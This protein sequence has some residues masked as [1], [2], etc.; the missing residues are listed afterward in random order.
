[1]KTSTKSSGFSKGCNEIPLSEKIT[2]MGYLF[3][4]HFSWPL[5][6]EEIDSWIRYFI[7]QDISKPRGI[8]LAYL[9]LPLCTE[10]FS[11]HEGSRKCTF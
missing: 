8:H 1:M 11:K 9:E 10:A 7:M 5:N 3:Q 4:S 6:L 2:E